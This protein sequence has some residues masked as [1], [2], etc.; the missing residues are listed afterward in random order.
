MRYPA[1]E[2]A[3]IIRLVETS[4]LPVRRTLEK[5]GIPR[6]T[7]Y[8]WYDRHRNG[9]P[10]ALG[11]RSP[12]PDRVWNRIPEGIRGQII[13]LAL[14]RSELSPRELAVCFTDEKRYFVSE[15]SVYR[16][17]KAHDLITSPAYVVIK[18]ASEFKDK[19]T[20]P[21]QLWQTDFTC[22][23]VTG[24]GWYY[25]S[26]VLDDFSRFIVAWKLCATMRAEDVTETLDL[27]LAAAGLEQVT[28]A[29]R[30]R[31]LSDNGA[32]YISSD[33]AEW[34]DAKGMKHVRGAPYHPQTQGKIERWRQTLKNRIL[35]ENYYL[36]GDLEAQIGAFVEHYNH[37]RYHESLG[38]LAPADVY[39]GRGQTIL[40]ERERIK[41]Q[42]IEH[43]R[44]QHRTQAA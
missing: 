25:L 31:L 37:A 33:L 1:S 22:L 41:R 7:F 2:K 23:K 6:A 8:R 11:D 39:L 40:L 26:T 30:P 13:N 42:T 4:H 5:L 29:H 16:L 38:N 28:V 15:A 27:A 14:E 9:G 3:E 36:P 18:A 35:L 43:R 19:T 34:L 21:N 24:W 17:L 44:L 20:A 32:S 12:R 10:E